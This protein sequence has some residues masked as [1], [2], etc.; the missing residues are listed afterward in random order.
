MTIVSRRMSLG[1]GVA[2]AGAALTS[3]TTRAAAKN[4]QDADPAVPQQ[5]LA[6]PATKQLVPLP[7]DAAK[8]EGMSSRLLTLHHDKN[9]A[10]AVKK[11]NAIRNKLASADASASGSYWSEYGTLKGGEAAARNSA[12]LHEFY[13]ANIIGPGQTAPPALA[14]ALGQRFGSVEGMVKQMKACG[15]ATSGWVVL[16]FDTASRTIEVVPTDGHRGG[17]WHA[18]ALVVLDVFEHSYALDFGP[19]KGSYLNAFFNNLNWT[20]VG[21]RFDRAVGG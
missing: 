15:K 18:E 21:G 13:F 7:F 5:P 19:D 3:C 6:A 9:Y 4:P 20:E 1:F 12:L 8:L 2:A 14:T 11:L 10:G 17:A 16:A